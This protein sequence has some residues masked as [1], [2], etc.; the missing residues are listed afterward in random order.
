MKIFYDISSAQT[1][2][3]M[4]I[5]GGGEYSL[6]LLVTLLDAIQ[7]DGLD[8]VVDVAR[9]EQNGLCQKL[10]LLKKTYHFNEISYDGLDSLEQILNGNQYDKCVFPV[11]Y[12]KFSGL[13]LSENMEVF[14]VIHDLCD[15]YYPYLEVKYGRFVEKNVWISFRRH[16]GKM[17]L[18]KQRY[19]KSLEAHKSICNMAKKQKIIT[20]THYSKST[21]VKNL[22]VPQES[23][24]VYYTPE[25]SKIGYQETDFETVSENYGIKSEKYFLLIAGSR[26]EK[27]NAIVL[28]V[29]DQMFSNK[30]YL[31]ELQDYRV[32]ILGVNENYERY[33]R[34]LLRNE[35]RFVYEGYVDDSTLDALYEHAHLFVFPSCL[36]GFGMPPL[37]AMSHGAVPACSMAMSIPEVCGNAAIYFDP[38]DEA[39]IELA[40][41][42]SFDENYMSDLKKKI[43]FHHEDMQ[44]RRAADLLHLSRLILS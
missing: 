10:D 38:H 8:C 39:S 15:L 17:F 24:L 13:Y 40:I 3:Y 16:L 34:H 14:T 11:C 20:V 7:N 33:Y 31:K 12:S 9:N 26:W 23:V 2:K 22:G 27:N 29:L 30:N 36:E 44:K 42:R 32:I 25:K 37:E 5:N 1:Q 43:K 18:A 35:E 21:I 19:Q 28:K 41:I 4:Q 6:T